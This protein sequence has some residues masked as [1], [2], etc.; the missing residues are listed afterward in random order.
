MLDMILQSVRRSNKQVSR[1]KY[2][3]RLSNIHITTTH[4]QA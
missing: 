3:Y 4:E 1:I 2:S